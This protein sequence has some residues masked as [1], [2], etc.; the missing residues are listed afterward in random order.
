M[1]QVHRRLATNRRVI[2]LLAV[3]LAAL[4]SA[5]L[6]IY[7]STSNT[8]SSNGTSSTMV[9][10]PAGCVKPANGFLIIASN[11]GY[12]DSIGHDAGPNS[13]WPVIRVQQ[14]QT[15]NIVVCNIDVQPH[16]FQINHYFDS[17]I[18]TLDPGQ[19][20]KLTPFVASQSGTFQ[21]YCSIFCTI[22]IYMQYGQLVVSS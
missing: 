15:V 14:G 12:N 3:V 7:T 9:K 2:L 5:G 21:I 6:V 18:E 13:P 1:R 19:V 16:G 11:L 17:N 10:L 4:A 20:I 8:A 22:H